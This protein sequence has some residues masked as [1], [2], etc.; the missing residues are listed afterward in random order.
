MDP[1]ADLPG[2][3]GHAFQRRLGQLLAGGGF[4]GF[5]EGLCAPVYHESLACR[6]L[7]ERPGERQDAAAGMNRGGFSP[8]RGPVRASSPMWND[9]R[10][11]AWACEVSI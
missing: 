10:V 3:S 1:A 11:Q 5:V 2:A 7:P 8:T 6:D 4:D 9:P